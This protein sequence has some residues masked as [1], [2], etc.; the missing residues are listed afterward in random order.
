ML[1]EGKKG[2]L[3]KQ[4]RS[5]WE[6][7]RQ[8]AGLE[9][10]RPNPRIMTPEEILA[11]SGAKSIEKDINERNKR[12]N[13]AVERILNKMK[14]EYLYE[15]VS[16][17]KG[18]AAKFAAKHGG[19]PQRRTDKEIAQLKADAKV[20]REPI[21]EPKERKQ[22]KGL[23]APSRQIQPTERVLRGERSTPKGLAQARLNRL[24]KE[25]RKA[26]LHMDISDIS[27]MGARAERIK[28]II[29]DKENWG[30]KRTLNNDIEYV[31]DYLLDEG[32]VNSYED[33]IHLM[34]LMSTEWLGHILI[35]S[36]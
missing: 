25:L 3:R 24:N 17:G 23:R 2:K 1:L 11:H 14:E 31:L 12:R 16:T 9:V 5:A 36:V 8:N 28:K 35:E 19:I 6:L 21:P 7:G 10:V 20:S 33:G 15:N 26:N 4:L 32:Y 29:K 30:K 18:A 13:K 27:R 22:R 34:E